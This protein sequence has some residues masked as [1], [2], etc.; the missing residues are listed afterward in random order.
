MHCSRELCRPFSPALRQRPAR[1]EPGWSER[2]GAAAGRA[3]R[4]REPRHSQREGAFGIVPPALR[5]ERSDFARMMLIERRTL[6]PE[7]SG[8]R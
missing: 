1:S 3:H 2:Q 6:T 8:G 5:I 4:T 7:R